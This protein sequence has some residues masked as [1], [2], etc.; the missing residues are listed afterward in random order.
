MRRGLLIGA[1]MAAIMIAASLFLMSGCGEKAKDTI[2]APTSINFITDYNSA[3]QAAQQKGQ[4]IVVDFYTDWCTWC[5]RLDTV[6]YVDS[7][8]IALSGG[9]VFAK[10]NA[11]VD[12]ATADKYSVSGYPTIV[13]M[14]SD[15]TEIDRI[16]GYLPPKEFVETINNYLLDKETLNDYLRRAQA[17]PTT[18]VD[19]ILG[20]KYADRGM[21][22]T[23][24]MYYEKVI[25]VDPDIKD[26]LAADAM[27]SIG[28]LLLR[29][30]TYDKAI[31][32]FKIVIDKFGG[33]DRASDAELWSGHAYR[34]MGD[35]ST[36]IAVYEQFLKNHPTREDST[37]I[38]ELINKL[39]NP[40]PPDSTK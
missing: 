13:L 25:A 38:K 12:T 20:Q 11:E 9:L 17:N 21:T 31:E 3:L 27:L 36:A 10:I 8:V 24:T 2:I 35:T 28:D 30:K 26:T 19:F 14:N 37:Q 4:K 32:R 6:T 34:K 5:K 16:G 15:G 33:T 22:D 18:E 40:P 29:A 1:T 23:A 39:K 7:T